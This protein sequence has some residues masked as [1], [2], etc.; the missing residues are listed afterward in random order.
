MRGRF[1]VAKLPAGDCGVKDQV[2]RRE[3]PFEKYL[4]KLQIFFLVAIDYLY[5][6]AYNKTYKQGGV[7]MKKFLVWTGIVAMLAVGLVGCGGEKPA[8]TQ[9]VLR[10][11][12][13]ADFSPFE[14]MD[15]KGKMTGFD[16]ELMEAL[17]KQMN[18]KLDH[19]NISF[20]GLIPAV[21]SGNIDGAISAISMTPDRAKAILFS[22]PYYQSGL[23][24]VVKEGNTEIKSMADLKGKKIAVQIGSTGANKANQIEGAIVREFNLSPDTFLELK[25]GNVDAI[26]NDLPVVQVFLKEQKNSGVKIVGDPEE[27]ENYGIV[28]AQKNPELAK[29]LNAALAELKKNGEYGKIYEKW[30]GKPVNK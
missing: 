9:K 27:S 5:I 21:Q 25:N 10:V 13:S 12:T 26:V 22:E 16:V 19:Q 24:V 18:R 4:Q 17:A 15:E 8:A 6:C 23:V 1:R 3:V 30:F 14:F 7:A 2:S 11:G 20:D 28:M 29:E